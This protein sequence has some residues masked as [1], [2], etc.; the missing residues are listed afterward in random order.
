MWFDT[1]V[2]DLVEPD[3]MVEFRFR[4]DKKL[5]EEAKNKTRF[6]HDWAIYM[7]GFQM[8][9]LAS[10]LEHEHDVPLEKFPYELYFREKYPDAIL[11][12]KHSK[13]TLNIEFEEFSSLFHGHD[14]KECDLIV[15]LVDD[16]DERKLGK[17]PVDIYEIK[18]GKLHKTEIEK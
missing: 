3:V 2:Y 7:F 9:R 4:K 6:Y 15:C 18:S 1:L 5:Y 10:K 14:P 17:Q 16:W 8:G 13:E 12:N 11:V